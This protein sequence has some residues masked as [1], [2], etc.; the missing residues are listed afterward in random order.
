MALSNS[1]LNISSG[2]TTKRKSAITNET[3]S[4]VVSE[5]VE[6]NVDSEYKIAKKKTLLLKK[7]T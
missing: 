3:V 1:S 5:P 7:L 6:I 4:V 2:L